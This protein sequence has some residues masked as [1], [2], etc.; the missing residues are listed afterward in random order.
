MKILLLPEVREYLKELQIILYKKHYFGFEEAAQE[1]TDE[2]LDD[3]LLTLPVRPHRPA[4]AY[5]NKYGK[6]LYYAVFTKNKR[7]QWYAFCRVYRENGELCYQIRYIA[8]NHT[9][10]QYL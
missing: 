5:F 3:I 10:A 6:G 7:T 2:L 1:Y 4:P 8:N 9:I